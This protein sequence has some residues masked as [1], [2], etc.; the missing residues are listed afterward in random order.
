MYYTL[1]IL[2]LC[3]KNN[4]GLTRVGFSRGCRKNGRGCGR[5]RGEG[6]RAGPESRGRG[7]VLSYNDHSCGASSPITVVLAQEPVGVI[8][9]AVLEMY[10]IRE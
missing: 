2:L 10:G 5:G 7:D 1:L 8:R 3:I 9:S 4:V 6:T